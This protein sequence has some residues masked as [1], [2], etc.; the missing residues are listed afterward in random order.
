MLSGT[1]DEFALADVFRLISLARKTGRLDVE[2]RAGAGKVFFDK[3]EVY[4][5]ESSLVREPLGQKLVRSGALTEG[6]LRRAL[7]EHVGSGERVGKILV[8]SRAVTEKDLEDAVRGQTEDAVFDLLRWERGEFR[9]E[10]GD[11]I[12]T[13]VPV[14]VS[15]ENLI[16]EA[17]R[18]L[19]ELEI[20]RR[21]IPSADAVMAMAIKPPEGAAEIN[22]TPE[23]WRLL[24]L[25][26]G[27]RSVRE[28]A[29]TVSVD[30]FAAMR[31]L[32]GLVSAGL[33]EIVTDPFAS[34]G[35]PR[36]E[37]WR[38]RVGA[39]SDPDKPAW[40]EPF[41]MPEELRSELGPTRSGRSE[42][43]KAEVERVVIEATPVDQEDHA[44]ETP[45][46]D[47]PRDGEERSGDPAPASEDAPEARAGEAR[48]HS[49][50]SD[51]GGPGPE[52]LAEADPE[53]VHRAD[54][55]SLQ[56]PVSES[57]IADAPPAQWFQDPEVVA[58]EETPADELGSAA[59]EETWPDDLDVEPG[60]EGERAP[61]EQPAADEGPAGDER[62]A[63]EERAAEPRRAPE[64]RAAAD[65][66][67]GER[68]PQA[69]VDRSAVVRELAGLF[70]A[71]EPSR[72]RPTPAPSD[73]ETST[74]DE[75]DDRKRVEDDEQV[76]KS[77]ISRLI[78]GVK[79]L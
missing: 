3:G 62:P 30:E 16:M 64:E 40:L 74:S 63:P 19:D 58:P 13:E 48:P 68:A 65:E 6:Q 50:V 15:V 4:Y 18:R 27:S 34:G 8:A 42:A 26:D 38:G 49:E 46:L 39:E 52:P 23:E 69:P 21:R 59:P 44:M 36:G 33:V 41:T 1:L 14:A 10:P 37:A 56:E 17:S 5:A 43:E 11:E 53:L 77:L 7:D 67:P 66:R 79:G 31:T 71:A 61:E 45:P 25:V 78:D 55:I 76:T 24:V 70:G 51:R 20:I 73:A 72:P 47:Q 9:W 60:I 28:I 32:Y 12:E 54:V 22:I 35:R 2:R 57:T 75:P 29:A